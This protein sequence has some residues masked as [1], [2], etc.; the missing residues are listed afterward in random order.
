MTSGCLLPAPCAQ[1]PPTADSQPTWTWMRWSPSVAPDGWEKRR[2]YWSTEAGRRYGDG[3]TSAKGKPHRK[4]LITGCET[5]ALLK[6]AE[7]PASVFLFARARW[8]DERA[9]ESARAPA[10]LV[11]VDPRDRF[12]CSASWVWWTKPR[13]P[14]P[15]SPVHVTANGPPHSRVWPSVSIYTRFISVSAPR[16]WRNVTSNRI[17]IKASVRKQTEV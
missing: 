13:T 14:T 12:E 17:R 7:K 1:A 8:S 3:G 10:R 2:E 16:F 15:M 11:H 9:R 4:P 5:Q 6:K